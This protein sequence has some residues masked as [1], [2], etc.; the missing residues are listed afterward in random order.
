MERDGI[1][2]LT[3]DLEEGDEFMFTSMVTVGDTKSVGTEYIRY[4]NIAEDDTESLSCVTGKEGGNLVANTAGS[5]TFTY[6]P[7]TQILTVSCE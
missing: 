4:T 6:D 3:V 7:S 5:Y 2:S 1:Y